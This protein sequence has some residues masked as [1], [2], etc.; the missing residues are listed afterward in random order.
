[1]LVIAE[2]HDGSGAEHVGG[3]VRAHSACAAGFT[4]GGV[5]RSTLTSARTPYASATARAEPVR[6]RP[7]D[8]RASA[9]P[10]PAACRSG[11]PPRESR[12]TRCPR[13][14]CPTVQTAGAAGS[15]RRATMVCSAVIT[16]AAA[17]IGSADSCGRAP[18]APAPGQRDREGVGRRGE[19]A[20][21]RRRLRPPRSVG[22]R[23]RRRWPRT[24]SSAPLASIGRAPAPSSSAGCNTT[25]TSPRPGDATSEHRGADRPRGVHVVPAGVHDPR[26][27]RGVVQP[28]R[29]L[30]RE[31]VDVAA[32][33]DDRGG[34]VAPRKRATTPV[35]AT[36]DHRPA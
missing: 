19:R 23:A 31:R 10:S 22:R 18:C 7:P 6:P 29:L 35:L 16:A 30:D 9:R 26:D 5:P 2:R 11:P 34:G 14:R 4:I 25:R 1:M 20:R 15:S 32:Q 8:G 21:P 12:W 17:T 24:P 28:G 36:R 33:R 13:A 3:A 27:R